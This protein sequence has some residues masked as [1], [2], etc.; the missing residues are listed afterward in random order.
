M[1]FSNSDGISLDDKLYETVVICLYLKIITNSI[2]FTLLDFKL[3]KM[4]YK[5]KEILKKILACSVRVGRTAHTVNIK[6]SVPEVAITIDF[7]QLFQNF[8]L[9]VD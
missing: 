6:W 8:F 9:I 4:H 2:F 5:V 1:N 3:S 7:L